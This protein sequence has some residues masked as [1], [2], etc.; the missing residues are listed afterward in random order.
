VRGGVVIDVSGRTVGRLTVVGRGEERLYGR[1]TWCCRC[2]CRAEVVGRAQRNTRLQ[3]VV[4][5]SD[6]LK[7]KP[8]ILTHSVPQ[9]IADV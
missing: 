3:H 7:L 1:V 5:R 2:T 8:D 9:V 6:A 4:F